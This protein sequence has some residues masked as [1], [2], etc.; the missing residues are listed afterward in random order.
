MI[1]VITNWNKIN[2]EATWS[3]IPYGI[4]QGL[5]EFTEVN[6]IDI[7]LSKTQYILGRGI[8]KMLW[9]SGA[10]ANPL[11]KYFE[12]RNIEK[13][14]NRFESNLYVGISSD[15]KFTNYKGYIYTDLTVGSLEYFRDRNPE[16]Y[17]FSGFD[18]EECYLEKWNKNQRDS[19][20]Y[21]QG[22][23]T[24]SKWLEEYLLNVE[25]MPKEKVHYIGGGMNL[26][27][28]LVDSSYK[29][30][31]KILFVGRDFKRKGGEEVLK[32]FQ[33]LHKKNPDIKLFI[34]GSIKKE[35]EEDG[36]IWL[37]NLP[38]YE[39]YY[40]YNICDIFCLPSHFEAFGIAFVEALAFGLPCIA[41]NAF[42]M[43]KLIDDGVT[44]ILL[45]NNNIEELVDSIEKILSDRNYQRNVWKLQSYYFNEYT[46]NTVADRIYRI[47]VK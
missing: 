45:K 2:P 5:K 8:N 37:G 4:M 21:L 44:G 35:A 32:A 42:E 18:L 34:A 41:R 13:K 47:M 6:T 1:N 17:K 14:V 15:I 33:V 28:E 9:H 39:L 26:K 22:I 24:M 43:P 38:N 20:N 19:F 23:F 3:G 30:G 12:S 40:Y 16:N 29:E 11:E 7:A 46:W 36:V 25:G 10:N 27:R 31:N